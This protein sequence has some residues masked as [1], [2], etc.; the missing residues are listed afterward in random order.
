MYREIKS[1]KEGTWNR[2]LVGNT[3][4]EIISNENLVE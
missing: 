4:H 3:I 1:L 2:Q